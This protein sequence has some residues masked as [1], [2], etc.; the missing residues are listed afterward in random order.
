MD[1]TSKWQLCD[2]PGAELDIDD[3]LYDEHMS[4]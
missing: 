1:S 4:M 3:D 2:N